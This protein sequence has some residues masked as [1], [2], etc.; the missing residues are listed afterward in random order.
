MP[1]FARPAHRN[2]SYHGAK[3]IFGATKFGPE[4]TSFRNHR[5]QRKHV[6]K[7]LVA[8]VYIIVAVVAELRVTKRFENPIAHFH[9][10]ATIAERL[11]KQHEPFDTENPTVAFDPCVVFLREQ[12]ML[13]TVQIRRVP[14]IRVMRVLAT[15]RKSL[16]VCRLVFRTL[17]MSF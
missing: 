6:G 3:K 7:V 12:S 1:R 11:L 5:K 4:S 10:E 15:V 14:K 2:I 16:P 8:F 17:K 9:R 13:P